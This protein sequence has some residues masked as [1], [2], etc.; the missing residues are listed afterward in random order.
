MKKVNADISSNELSKEQRIWF[1]IETILKAIRPLLLYV[2]LPGF[3]MSLGMLLFG[4]RTAEEIKSGSGNF[5]YMLGIVVTILIMYKR[6]KKRG[7]TLFEEASLHLRCLERQKVINLLL[8]GFGFGFFFSALVTVVPFP[9]FLIEDYRNSSNQLDAETD[10]YLALL[11]TA[12][13]A[14]ITEEIIFRG[15]MMNRLQTWF[16]TRESVLI[17]TVLFALCHVSFIW[18]VYAFLMG[19]MLAGISIREKNIGYSVALHIGFNMNVV[20]IW[21]INHI[22]ALSEVLFANHLLI[23]GYGIVS[24]CVGLYFLKKYRKETEK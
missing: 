17:T 19:L 4:G 7:S 10:Q 21:I 23:A 12:V 6:S 5:Y 2:M 9:E 1:S 14:P 18:I 16:K 22:P 15:Y 11:S 8:M 13:L 3:F 20:P 24:C